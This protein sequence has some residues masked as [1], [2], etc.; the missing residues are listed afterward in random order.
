MKNEHDHWHQMELDDLEEENAWQDSQRADLQDVL[1]RAFR[2]LGV[3]SATLAR[4]GQIDT[5]ALRHNLDPT[6]RP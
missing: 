2:K 1:T 3:K 4:I 5:T 6:P